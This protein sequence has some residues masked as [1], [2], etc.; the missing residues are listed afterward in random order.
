MVSERKDLVLSL[1]TLWQNSWQMKLRKRIKKK[2]AL[3]TYIKRLIHWPW[4][5]NDQIGEKWLQKN[6]FEIIQKYL[7]DQYQ[8][9][10]ENGN[11]SYKFYV[12]TGVPQGSVLA[13]FLFLLYINDQQKVVKD[14]QKVM[15]ADD[16][17][18]VKCGK[19]TERKINEDPHRITDW[20]R[21]SKLTVKIGK[22]NASIYHLSAYCQDK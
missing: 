3:L 10:C 9:V 18:T 2:L 1:L 6:N 14:S 16:T 13:P 4:N 22:I 5:S 19:Y 15:F 17:T 8:F 21:A 7:S 12:K 20:F 11:H